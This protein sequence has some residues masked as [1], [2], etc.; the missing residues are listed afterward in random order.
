MYIIVL[1]R[2]QKGTGAEI[3]ATRNCF[4]DSYCGRAGQL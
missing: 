3:N 2:N 1:V 4:W